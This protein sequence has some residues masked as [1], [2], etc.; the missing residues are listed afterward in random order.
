MIVHDCAD[1]YGCNLPRS[2]SWA[3]AVEA[4]S[5]LQ[6]AKPVRRLNNSSLMYRPET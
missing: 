2:L 5:S 4:R 3:A 1:L 6:V